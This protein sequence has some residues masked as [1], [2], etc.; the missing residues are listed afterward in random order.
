MIRHCFFALLT[1]TVAAIAGCTT[2]SSC[3]PGRAETCPCPG[4]GTG[5]QTCGID[6][7]FGTCSCTATDAGIDVGEPADGGLDAGADAPATDSPP[8]PDVPMAID[9]PSEGGTGHLVLMGQ[10]PT[11]GDDG[12]DPMIANAVFLSERT[13]TLD[14]LV[15]TQY[16]GDPGFHTHPREVIT[17]AGEDR[18]RPVVLHDLEHAFDLATVLPTMDVLFVPVQ[19]SIERA[20]MRAIADGWHDTIVEFLEGGGVVLVMTGSTGASGSAMGAEALVASGEDLFEV[21]SFTPRLTLMLE[22][23][24]PTDPVAEGVVSP[25][26]PTSGTVCFDGSSGGVVVARSS[27]ELCPVVRHLAF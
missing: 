12:I 25:L 4:G 16:A 21:P 15:F 26:L 7:T 17:D 6:G 1:T 19:L 14:V 10:Y 2:T 9:A 8:D 11:M 18:E 3:I 24:T 23:V 5:V 20:G 27:T 13:G 22:I